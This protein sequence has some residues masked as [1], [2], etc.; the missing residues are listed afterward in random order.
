VVEASRPEVERIKDLSTDRL[1]PTSQY[2]DL[3]F[4]AM[5]FMDLRDDGSILAPSVD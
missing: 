5:L 3:F 2:V 4:R 1:A